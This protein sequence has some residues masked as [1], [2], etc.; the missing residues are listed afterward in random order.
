MDSGRAW[1]TNGD[2]QFSAVA[3]ERAASGSPLS[4]QTST[5]AR[6]DDFGFPRQ[7]RLTRGPDIQN[8]IREGKRI[9]TAYLD[10][11][12]LASPLGLS[13]IGIIV[14]RHQHSAVDR[15]RLKR[16]LRELV[17]IELLPLLRSGATDVAIRARREAYDAG[18][19]G[20]RRDIDTIRQRTAAPA[21]TTQWL[22]VRR[23][24]AETGSR[25]TCV[26]CSFSSFAGIKSR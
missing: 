24:I 10:V 23:P 2:V 20:L 15:N 11:R 14:P 17:R 19:D 26:P 5:Q 18:F 22:R 9:R 7:H 8:V 1:K 12:V 13:R 4:C 21:L 25:L 3:G 16:R 6:N